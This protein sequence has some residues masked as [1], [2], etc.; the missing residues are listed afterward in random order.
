MAPS[1][2]ARKTHIFL[3]IFIFLGWNKG[4]RAQSDSDISKQ[5]W[6]DFNP[7]YLV[8]P[9]F[10]IYGDIGTRKEIENK[11]WWRLVMRPSIRIPFGERYDFTA[12]IG[13]FYTF[14]EIIDD[15]WELR[16]FQG[17]RFTWPHGKFPFRHYIRLEERF[18]FN[19]VTW[20]SRNSARLRY[21]LLVS[22]RWKAFR[23]GR[24]WQLSASGEAFIT[25]LGQQGQFQELSRVTLGL[26][27]SYNHDLH[28]R[29]EITWQ[30]ERLFFSKN[31]FISD[32]Y[33]RFRFTKG[34]RRSK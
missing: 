11:G 2:L 18:D 3:L 13:N 10:E 8:S 15:R 21:Q 5:I 30:Q 17:L 25:L 23:P 7:S 27:R 26:D 12:G 9:G 28:I 24:F 14:N 31:E 16:P 34:W 1:R 22:Y 29:F 19:T 33:F 20:K 6:L 4:I 32:I